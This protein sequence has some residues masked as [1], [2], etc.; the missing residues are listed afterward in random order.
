MPE[1]EPP[2]PM[3]E[4]LKAQDFVDEYNRRI[5]VNLRRVEDL[6]N[7]AQDNRLPPLIKDDILRAAVVLLHATLEDFL[8]YIGGRYIPSGGEDVLDKIPVVGLP[9]RSERLTLGKLAKHRDKTVDQLIIE[10][11]EARL[12]KRSF[13]S[14]N[15]VTSLLAS[16][17]VPN[18]EVETYYSSLS[19]LIA[20]RHGIVHKGDLI[21]SDNEQS[22]RNAQPIDA[23][24][25][26]EWYNTVYDFITEVAAYKLKTG[27]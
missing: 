2:T 20:R 25:V 3:E 6:V 9:D 23:A 7:F 27:V 8:R 24:K 15:E 14:T 13:S 11:V 10:S 17:G 12:D 22:E 5:A 1:V 16:I 18:S 4:M 19:E 26:I 21:A